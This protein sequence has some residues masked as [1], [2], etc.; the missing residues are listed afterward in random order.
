MQKMAPKVTMNYAVCAYCDCFRA[1][2]QGVMLCYRW[3]KM[4]EKPCP[5]ELELALKA[6]DD[7]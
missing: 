1:Y 2:A 5:Y 7:G 6:D 4:L 3:V